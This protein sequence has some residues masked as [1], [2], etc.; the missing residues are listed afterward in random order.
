MVPSYPVIYIPGR[1]SQELILYQKINIVR[2]IK[3][4][5]ENDAYRLESFRVQI[6]L[7]CIPRGC[8]DWKC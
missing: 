4:L 8:D 3:G 1:R 5:N 2:V 7:L 6:Y